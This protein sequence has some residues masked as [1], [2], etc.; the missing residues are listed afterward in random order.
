MHECQHVH[1]QHHVT[2]LYSCILMNICISCEMW[3]QL[4]FWCIYTCMNRPTCI[5]LWN[6]TCVNI[7]IHTN[8]CLISE[9]ACIWNVYLCLVETIRMWKCTYMPK[10]DC[11]WKLHAYDHTCTQIFRTS[12]RSCFVRKCACIWLCSKLYACEHV[13]LCWYLCPEVICI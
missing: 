9:A 2:L 1:I 11:F 8:I 5:V 3:P 6:C 12:H 13:C 10:C 4:K 7:Q